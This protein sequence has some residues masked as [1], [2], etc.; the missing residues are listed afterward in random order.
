[1]SLSTEQKKYA[2]AAAAVTATAVAGYAIY[3]FISGAPEKL[4]QEMYYDGKEAYTFLG[5]INRTN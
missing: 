3:K 5:I 2:Y 1:M 4:G